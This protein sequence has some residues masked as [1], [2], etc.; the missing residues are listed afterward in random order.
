[1][2]IIRINAIWCSACISM[3]K[4]WEKI[5]KSYPEIEIVTYDYD[6]DEDEIKEYNVG[7]VLPVAIFYKKDIEVARLNGEKKLEDIIKVIEEN[8]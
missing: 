6:M 3:H 5:E 2:K 7:N 8:K 4:I 1:M